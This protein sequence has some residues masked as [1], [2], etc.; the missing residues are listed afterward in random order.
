MSLLEKVSGFRTLSRVFRYEDLMRFRRTRRA[1]RGE[2]EYFRIKQL[3]GK[4]VA[5]RPGTT[6]H[7]V[8]IDT[9]SSLFHLPPE[10]L[11]AN[12]KI[13]D[14]G[15]NVGYTAAH[16]AALFPT[17]TVYAV[18][19]DERNAE[20]ARR[21]TEQFRPRVSIIHCAVWIENGAMSYGGG[22]DGEWAYR[23]DGLGAAPGLSTV[24]T[25]TLDTLCETQGID[26][27]DFLKM[28]IEG[29]ESRVLREHTNW[30]G[31]VQRINLEV[32]GPMVLD[33]ALELLTQHGFECRRHPTHPAAVLGVRCASK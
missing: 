18:E 27:I 19:M 3:G 25:Q 4:A 1:G 29:A 21:N 20:M 26:R 13:L 10:S 6:D 31:R 11:P 9:F 28:D 24:A 2:L 14:L 7:Q 5:C 32:H 30:L 16:F 17:A 15:A 12:P 23:L 8:L 22:E 33:E